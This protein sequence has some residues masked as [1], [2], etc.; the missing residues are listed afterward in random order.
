MLD[1]AADDGKA[2]PTQKLS[3]RELARDTKSPTNELNRRD[4]QN[5]PLNQLDE[6]DDEKARQADQKDDE[7][8]FVTIHEMINFILKEFA[9]GQNQYRPIKEMLNVILIRGQLSK[10]NRISRNKALR[11]FTEKIEI[12]LPLDAYFHIGINAQIDHENAENSW[13]EKVFNFYS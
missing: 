11:A 9:M 1:D 10:P 3:A 5:N 8:D 4:N 13:Y 6:Q 12:K 7:P 2:S